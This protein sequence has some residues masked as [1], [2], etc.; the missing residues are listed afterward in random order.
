MLLY[1]YIG[2]TLYVWYDEIKHQIY[3]NKRLKEEGYKFTGRKYFGFADIVIGAFYLAALSIPVLNLLSPLSHR[4]KE[5]SYDE[6]KN[7]LD[8]AGAIEGPELVSEREK[9]EAKVI[10]IDKTKLVERTNREGHTYYSPMYRGEDE[11]EEEQR[12]YAYRKV[13]K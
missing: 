6:Y 11:F 12:G 9:L 5:R 8:E 10:K 1:I 4:N 7:Y 2:S 13:L 3:L